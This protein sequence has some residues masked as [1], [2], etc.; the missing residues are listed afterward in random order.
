MAPRFKPCSIDNCNGNA[1]ADAKGARGWCRAH[2][3][4]WNRYGD[5]MGGRTR[6]GEPY[7][8]IVDHV[9]HDGNAC[10]IWPYSAIASGY[11]LV[12]GGGK[13]LFAHR[14]MCQLANGEPPSSEHEAAHSCGNGH[15]GCVH[16]K[17]L[18][19]DTHQGNM[20][21]ILLHDTHTRGE[22]QP[23]HKLTEAEV[24]TIRSLYGSGNIS[25]VQLA[26]QFGVGQVQIG[27]IIRRERWAWLE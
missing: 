14:E 24:L 11:G 5:P 15:L 22:R 20:G 21:D 16:P 26:R 8:W 23:T 10:L 4:R 1:H 9:A 12:K 13:R 6:L 19:W 27:R 17:H 7:Q 18:R 2:Y 25:Q 3:H